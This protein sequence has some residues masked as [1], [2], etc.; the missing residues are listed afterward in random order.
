MAPGG[1][2]LPAR[3]DRPPGVGGVSVTDRAVS[4]G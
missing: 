2:A 3:G 1:G 4:R